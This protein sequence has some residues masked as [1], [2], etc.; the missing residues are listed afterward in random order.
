MG[1]NK[2]PKAG[3]RPGIQSLHSFQQRHGRHPHAQKAVGLEQARVYGNDDP[4]E[5]QDLD[6]RL[7]LQPPES[8]IR[9]E[10]RAGLHRHGQS[11]LGHTDRRRVPGHERPLMAVRHKQLFQRPPAVRREKQKGLGQDEGRVR[12]RADR[13][14]GG[15]KAEDVLNQ[16]SGEQHKEGEGGENKCDRKGDNPRAI[17][18][19]PVWKETVHTQNEDIAE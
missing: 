9:T 4:R 7:P 11:A 12:R 14:S 5:Q 8:Q 10:V 3:V 1:A 16:E 19:S 18:R 13:R 6:V 2:D 15:A 17:Q